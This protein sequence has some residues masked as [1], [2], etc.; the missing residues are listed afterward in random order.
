VTS[1]E[2]SYRVV[3]KPVLSEKATYDSGARNAYHFRVPLDANKVE[4]RRAV[5]A[6]FGVKVL[7]VNTLRRRGKLRRR[8]WTSGE[9]QAWKRAMVTLAEGNTIEI[10]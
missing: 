1:R 3:Q 4:I 2:R 8:G 9:S 10:L 5:E 6:L 7:R